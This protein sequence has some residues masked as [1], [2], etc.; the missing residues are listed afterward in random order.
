VLE[1]CQP[2]GQGQ[3]FVRGQ[4]KGGSGITIELAPGMYRA[5]EC[6]VQSPGDPPPPPPSLLRTRVHDDEAGLGT[7]LHDVE[8]RLTLCEVAMLAHCNSSRLRDPEHGYPACEACLRTNADAFKAVC[9]K[10]DGSLKNPNQHTFC[11][12]CVAQGGCGLGSSAALQ[13]GQQPCGTETGIVKSTD[14]GKSWS[15]YTPI[16]INQSWAT[17]KPLTPKHLQPQPAKRSRVRRVADA[18]GGLAHGIEMVQ[19]GPYKGRLA[20]ARHFDCNPNGDPPELQRDFVLYSDD[21]VRC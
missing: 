21:K 5:G 3:Q 1:K 2:K 10:A 16:R 8:G 17:R 4:M 20:L 18:G 13:K 9:S 14:E 15:S 7:Q 6:L 12:G 19:E 11:G